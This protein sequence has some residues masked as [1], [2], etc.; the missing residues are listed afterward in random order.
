MQQSLDGVVV[1]KRN[2]QKLDE[3]ITNITP[4]PH[5]EVDSLAL[6]SDV[7]NGIQL[8]GAPETL[9]P[10]SELLVNQ[11]GMTS[12]RGLDRRKRGRVLH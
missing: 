12:G 3:E 4:S 7:S 8:I 11:E 6:H 9:E 1:K 2:R 5:G 10:N